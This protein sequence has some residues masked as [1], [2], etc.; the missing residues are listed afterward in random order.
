M[1]H[2]Q[3]QHEVTNDLRELINRHGY[4]TL[5]NM[6]D[7]VVAPYLFSCLEALRYAMEAA[8]PAVTPTVDGPTD[9]GPMNRSQASPA[10]EVERD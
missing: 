1:S 10:G 7:Y 3:K 9:H 5:T 2:A 8:H 4:D 6:P